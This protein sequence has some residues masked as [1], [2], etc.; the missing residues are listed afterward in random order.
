MI[1]DLINE[2][3]MRSCHIQHMNLKAG[4][5]DAELDEHP[6]NLASNSDKLDAICATIDHLIENC[7]L[8]TSEAKSLIRN[9]TSQRNFYGSY[10]EL[11]AYGWL[12]CHGVK[13]R[14]QI[15]LS[16]VDV[17]NPH[18]CKI[19]G[20]IN[21]PSIYFD[22]KA[23]GFQEYVAEVFRSSLEALL[24]GMT[25]TIDGSMDNDVSDINSHAFGTI[26][27][28]AATMKNGGVHKIP[29]LHWTIHVG[30]PEPVSV[31]TQEINPYRLA[32]ENRYYPFK[33]ARQFTRNKSFLLIFP[34]S[35]AFNRMLGQNFT[36][37]T[38]ITLR[39]L[40]RRAFMQLSHDQT[41]ARKF[42]K[43]VAPNVTIANASK[44]LSGLLFIDL[45][46]EAAG[47]LFLNPRA[48]HNLSKDS[49]DQVFDFNWPQ[50]LSFDDFSYDNY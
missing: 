17:L 26:Q 47:W 10:C 44:L 34:Y 37:S 49:M 12:Q 32:E 3:E 19:D 25:V 16:A 45:D 5:S 20:R 8:A 28:L 33:G 39:S 14:T 22:I 9:L 6:F 11:R 27:S 50:S 4:L 21:I 40:A 35:A 23:F 38:E 1:Y 43:S 13:F 24:P 15:Q 18:G 7:G 31:S 29:Q 30:K 36:G 48:T 2:L 41:S 42:D 46:K